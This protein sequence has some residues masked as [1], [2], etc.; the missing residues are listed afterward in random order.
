MSLLEICEGR[1][2]QNE[3]SLVRVI[4]DWSLQNDDTG[5]HVEHVGALYQATI[6]LVLIQKIVPEIMLR[7]NFR[8]AEDH[9][10]IL[11]TG[12]SHIPSARVVQE[13]NT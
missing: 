4:L 9:K 5:L 6:V 10:A 12:Q 13:T 2:S 1:L 3:I 11:C 8:I 7:E